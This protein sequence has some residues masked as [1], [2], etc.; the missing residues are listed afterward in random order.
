MA[1]NRHNP[2]NIV[3]IAAYICTIPLANYMIGHVGSCIPNGP[4]LITVLPGVDAPSGVILVG[5][6]LVLRDLVQKRLGVYASLA[7]VF[8]GSLVTLLISPAFALASAT[9]FL[10]S[11][12]A[13][14]LVYTPLARTR[15]KTAVLL[16]CVVGSAVDS[17]LFLSLAFGSLA[18]I[19][20]QIIGKMYAALA[21]VAWRLVREKH[22]GVCAKVT[23]S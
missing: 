20:G 9:A 12:L 7:C 10:F 11:E 22:S 4:C 18:F 14:F 19:G 5:A 8:V 15:F 23:A 21:F 1:T 6:A 3:I 13:D 17:A 2:T 16:S